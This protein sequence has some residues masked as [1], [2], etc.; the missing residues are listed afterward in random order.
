MCTFDRFP[1]S[2]LVSG[3]TCCAAAQESAPCTAFLV[4]SV[5]K[6]ALKEDG[7]FS[8]ATSVFVG[9]MEA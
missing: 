3:N 8:F 7:A 6:S 5:P 9:P 2:T 4:L 1:R